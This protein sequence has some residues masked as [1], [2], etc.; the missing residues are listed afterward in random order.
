MKAIVCT[1]YGDPD[2]LEL[3]EVATPRPKAGEVLV[4]V[5]ATTVSRADVEIRRFAFAAWIW[6]PLRLA[7]GIFRPRVRILGQEL[8]GEVEALGTGLTSFAPGDR[9]YG[10]TGIG[11]GG[12]AEYA[13]L[14][15]R[16]A[17][18]VVAPMP[19]TL[20]FAEAA[21]VPYGA[22]EAFRFLRKAGIGAGRRVLVIGAGG[23][24][25]SYAVQLAVHAGAE[26][27]AV[28]AG[29]KLALLRELGAAQVADYAEADWMDGLGDFDIV[30]DVICRAPFGRVVRLLRPGGRY[31]LANPGTSHLL[32]GLW[33]S[34]TSD[35]K[36]IFGAEAGTDDDLRA[37]GELIEA[38]ALRPVIDRTYSFAQMSE[39]HRYAET[40]Q[41]LGSI[42][43]LVGPEPDGET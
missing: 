16:R 31:L 7:F 11:A 14:G 33:T 2:V 37:L 38:G 19:A 29:G 25:G 8:A 5:R 30:F 23:S 6:L 32:R 15:G 9:V 40:E 28:D 12:Y 41:K 21:A 36:V 26:V 22:S 42:V 20:G 34:L 17:G 35:K 3:R 39:A 24:F 13:C 1:A 43:V 18:S 4:R 10:T 27:V